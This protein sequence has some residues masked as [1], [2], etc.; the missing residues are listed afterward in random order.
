MREYFPS[1][2]EKDT[3]YNLPLPLPALMTNFKETDK[4]PPERNS[5][6]LYEPG[7]I[8]L[9]RYNVCISRQIFFFLTTESEIRKQSIIKWGIFV[10]KLSPTQLRSVS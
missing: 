3:L 2:A 6:W 4:Q 10:I 9:N 1:L 7:K 5:L 8:N